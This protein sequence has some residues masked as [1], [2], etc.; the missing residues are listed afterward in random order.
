MDT[1]SARGVVG[2]VRGNEVLS[3]RWGDTPGAS[4]EGLLPMI[5]ECLEA[6]RMGLG[7]IYAMAVGRGPGSFTGTRISLATAKGFAFGRGIPI[8]TVSSMEAAALDAMVDGVVAV[9]LDAKKGEVLVAAYECGPG[10]VNVG[11]RE[12]QVRVTRTVLD[13]VLCEPRKAIGMLAG[14]GPSP[15]QRLVGDA[16]LILPAGFEFPGRFGVGPERDGTP[17]VHPAQ[18]ISGPL[19]L[20]WLALARMASGEWDDPDSVEPLYSRPPPGG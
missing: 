4:S 10:V 2:I 18:L 16:A 14:L 19:P 11:G 1:S 7:G 9:A 6:A 3:H 13:P 17:H 20:G 5:V 8:V 12:I 15:V